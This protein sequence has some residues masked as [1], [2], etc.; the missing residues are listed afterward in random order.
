VLKVIPTEV[1]TDAAPRPLPTRSRRHPA[2]RTAAA[3]TE[4]AERPGACPGRVQRA[5]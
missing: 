3:F 1:V 4:L 5:R 2:L